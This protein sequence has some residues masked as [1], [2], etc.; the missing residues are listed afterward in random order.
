MRISCRGNKLEFSCFESKYGQ[1]FIKFA[2]E[3]FAKDNQEIAK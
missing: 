1:E 3:K 2:A